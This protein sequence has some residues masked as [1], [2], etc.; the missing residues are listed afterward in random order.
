VLEAGD[1]KF[2]V[3][4]SV[5]E[6]GTRLIG[7]YN[8]ASLTVVEQLTEQA[9]T[10]LDK[11]LLADGTF[12]N[13][14]TDTASAVNETAIKD[15][16]RIEGEYWFEAIGESASYTGSTETFT[17][18]LFDI[19]TWSWKTHTGVA[20]KQG[21]QVSYMIYK[22]NAE[23]AGEYYFSIRAAGNKNAK[24]PA[25]F[26][27]STST[28][29]V[30]YTSVATITGTETYTASGSSYHG[31]EDIEM[32]GNTL[33]LQKGANY[34][35]VAWNAAGNVDSFSLTR[36]NGT[37]SVSNTGTTY[38][39]AYQYYDMNAASA[40]FVGKG[41]Y[42]NAS[43]DAWETYGSKNVESMWPAGSYATYKVYVE[44]EGTYKLKVRAS[45]VEDTTGLD[46]LISTDGTN[47]TA[48]G[49]LGAFKLT[50]NTKTAS[51]NTS[52]TTQYH[53]YM[54]T[55]VEGYLTLK[56]GVNYIQFKKGSLTAPNL[57]AFSLTA[58]SVYPTVTHTGTTRLEAESF[59][60][61]EPGSSYSE[62]AAYVETKTNCAEYQDGTWVKNVTKTYLSNAWRLKTLYYKV[63]CLKDG[64]YAFTA[65]AATN[66]TR[67]ATIKFAT[68]ADNYSK[69]V[70]ATLLDT[71]TDS[72]NMF[73]GYKET[74][75]EGVLRLKKGINIIKVTFGGTAP[76]IDYFTIYKKDADSY[77]QLKDVVN[78]T[79]TL[80]QFVQQMNTDE[81]ATFF[82][83]YAGATNFGGSNAVNSKFG[84]SRAAVADGPSGIGSKGTSF[85]CET[86]IACTWNTDLVEAFGRV[87]GNELYDNNIDVWLAPG[88]NLHRNPLLGRC[89]EYY[90]EDPFISGVMA[91]TTV[92]AVQAYGV[93]VCL[94]HFVCNEKEENKLS[95]EVQVSER[96]LR[97]IYLLPFEMRV[98]EGKAQGIMS[99]YNHINGSAM[100]ESYD[101]LTNIL[102]G[103]WGY[104]YYISGDWNNNNDSIAEINGGHGV[105][106]PENYCNV[107]VIIEA[108]DNGLITRETLEAGAK[109]TLNTLMMAKRNYSTYSDEVCA[110]GHNYV[111]TICSVCHAPDP[112]LFDQHDDTILDLAGN[113]SR[114][115]GYKFTVGE[116]AVTNKTGIIQG[117]FVSNIDLFDVE[118]KV[119]QITVANTLASK[120]DLKIKLGVFV[121]DD[122]WK[123]V[124]EDNSYTYTTDYSEVYVS[125]GWLVIPYGCSATLTQDISS[126]EYDTFMGVKNGEPKEYKRSEYYT[127]MY[128]HAPDAKAND[129]FYVSAPNIKF[130]TMSVLGCTVSNVA[131]D[132]SIIAPGA[133]T[134]VAQVE[135]AMGEMMANADQ[136]LEEAGIQYNAGTI[137]NTSV[138]ETYVARATDNVD[139]V[140]K[141]WYDAEGNVLSTDKYYRYETDS[142]KAG[143][144]TLYARY[145]ATQNSIM[146]ATLDIGSTLAVNYYARLDEAHKDAVL[147][148]TRGNSTEEISGALDSETGYYMFAYKNINP[149]CMAENI[150]AELVLDGQT[151]ALKNEYSVKAYCSNLANKTAAELDIDDLKHAQ[152]ITLLSDML[153]YGD[154]AQKYKDYKTEDHATKDIDWL[155]P[156]AFT[157][158]DGVRNV[159]GNDDKNNKVTSVGLNMGDANKIYFRVNVTDSDV[160]ITVNGQAVDRG[161]IIDGVVYTEDIK[162]TEFDKVYTVKLIKGEEVLSTVE[163]N[164]NAYIVQK[165]N[166][167][168]V[169]GL[170]TALNNYGVSAKA[171]KG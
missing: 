123:R 77:Y 19:D 74:V 102:R 151:F 52:S 54:D 88:M 8:H 150:K 35:K 89:S 14:N 170:V 60:S 105:R 119:E 141:G 46:V 2:Y 101:I 70:S 6:A 17:G 158:P 118:K 62:T 133:Y 167:A 21:D 30:T 171:Y 26:T 64:D 159:T 142:V 12:E 84:F 163:Y 29:N 127:I 50:T 161:E 33:S 56:A 113:I 78:G 162:A 27:V 59:I 135:N 81:L 40:S 93:S 3:G 69:T 114:T 137:Y 98:K 94:K 132:T 80:D 16:A 140:F 122:G 153:I 49:N 109:Y 143:Q 100:S 166:S 97:E 154:E 31:Y 53:N 61:F 23:E 83:S 144:Q 164:V 7:T 47:F 28:D 136:A 110:E 18:K 160:V 55:S 22:V 5:K 85:P 147:K 72:Q 73:N 87:M 58:T 65:L 75:A 39:P 24:Q 68:D 128:M 71:Y 107:N 96:A 25:R 32:L 20:P 168:T 129:T 92:K 15:Y 67:T 156:S 117:T 9:K 57:A 44:K 165:Y 36:V 148:V 125:G 34:V 121:S 149:Q 10:T 66:S 134:A 42:Y 126:S 1:Y 111:G 120:S 103:E 138:H 13:L 152:L 43:A 38:I 99:S 95:C 124:K 41:T 115:V 90:S 139:Y 45:S 108:I 157:K 145:K 51:G 104:K 155:K 86:V 106:E 76:N 11:R 169:G 91:V 146:G 37:H 63:D 79:V 48:D 131:N 4:N 130:S 112:E 116:G 82:V